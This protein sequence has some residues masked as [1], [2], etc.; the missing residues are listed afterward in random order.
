MS[1]IILGSPA[2]LTE[3]L[4]RIDEMQPCRARA[5]QSSTRIKD[6]FHWFQANSPPVG[7]GGMIAEG[8]QYLRQQSR[9]T[10]DNPAHTATQQVSLV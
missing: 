9:G 1:G 6:H 8:L 4:M 2:L 7:K 3:V 5:S 10:W